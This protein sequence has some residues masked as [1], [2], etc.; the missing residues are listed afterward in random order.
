MQTN[1]DQQASAFPGMKANLSPSK[2]SSY[3]SAARQLF[4]YA[5]CL[6]ANLE[7]Q[8]KTPAAATDITDI[9][10]FR[11]V[12]LHD[13]AHENK[14]DGLV[15]GVELKKPLNV[16]EKGEA[17][18]VLTENVTPADP[19]TAYFQGANAGKFAKTDDADS[20]LV[21][22]ARFKSNSITVDGV[23]IAILELY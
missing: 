4:G 3:S 22:N 21:P 12:C 7:S 2:V 11:G 20:A 17:Y 6:G 13:H 19:V 15:P 9:K 1:Y 5:L 16:L 10:L 23:I 18:V 14:A 8:V